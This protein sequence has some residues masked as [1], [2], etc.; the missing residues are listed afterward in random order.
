MRTGSKREAFFRG[1]PALAEQVTG[2]QEAVVA[3]EP[4]MLGAAADGSTEA[5]SIPSEGRCF[6]SMR[7]YFPSPRAEIP[8][9]PAAPAVV[10]LTAE[11]A[12]ENNQ[13]AF[14]EGLARTAKG[15]ATVVVNLCGMG[16]TGVEDSYGF[17]GNI[18][19]PERSNNMLAMGLNR[20]TVGL[21]AAE[22][23]ATLR[24]LDAMPAIARVAAVVARNNTGAALLHAAALANR[25]A[26]AALRGALDGLV[27][28]GDITSYADIAASRYYALPTWASI[29]G[30][31]Q[32][33]DLPELLAA[34]AASGLRFLALGPVDASRRALNETG[35]ARAYAL[36]RAA[37]EAKG[38]AQN[39]RVEA[40][41]VE[42]PA[43][44]GAAVGS[45]LVS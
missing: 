34:H 17:Q 7:V 27:A 11:P 22:V 30:V 36:P 45:W 18:F 37:F 19:A 41:A 23:L 1:L 15:V 16:D 35:A 38:F 43:E 10:L 4:V 29:P 24:A 2:F 12:T 31:L 21:H 42:D 8:A 6:V 13:S 14:R 33:Y 25:S 3:E 9:A 44:V 39:L 40:R 5:W 20:S 26:G 32:H 28:V